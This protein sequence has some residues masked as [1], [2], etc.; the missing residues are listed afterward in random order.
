[1]TLPP[2]IRGYAPATATQPCVPIY[3]NIP[4][5]ETGSQDERPEWLVLVPG[6]NEDAF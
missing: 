1:M 4:P 5:A 6:Y 3:V 2:I